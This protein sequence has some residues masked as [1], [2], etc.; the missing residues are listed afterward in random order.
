MN[1]L[2]SATANTLLT[3]TILIEFL[4]IRFLGWQFVFLFRSPIISTCLTR[5]TNIL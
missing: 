2:K 3:D 4:L 5:H 1:T